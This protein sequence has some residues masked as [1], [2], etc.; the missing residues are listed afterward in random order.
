MKVR[1]D[2]E[3]K[4]LSP[5]QIAERYGVD[6]S[7]VH[8]WIRSGELRAINVTK[9]LRPKKPRF[10][11][12][13]DDLKA[14]ENARAVIHVEPQTPEPEVRRRRRKRDVV[15][16]PHYVALFARYTSGEI[17]YAEFERIYDSNPT[18][19]KSTPV[20]PPVPKEVLE[21]REALAALSDRKRKIVLSGSR[22]FG[23][24][25]GSHP[26]Y[27]A[28]IRAE[29]ALKAEN[30]PDCYPRQMYRNGEVDDLLER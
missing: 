15:L 14:F 25:S 1:P 26:I 6:V 13:P 2:D 3:T 28:Y 18:L 9:E 11:V 17:T 22:E 21:Y 20:Q 10:K 16:S 23:R 29:N 7:K 12:Y 19:Y 8:A 5:P 30:I 4:L 24:L 27:K